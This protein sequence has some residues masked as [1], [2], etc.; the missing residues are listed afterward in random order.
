M[1]RRF[2]VTGAAGLIGRE[3]VRKLLLRGDEVVAILRPGGATGVAPGATVVEIDLSKPSAA[4]FSELGRYDVVIHLAQAAGWHDFPRNAGSIATVSLAATACLAEAAVAAGASTF[5]LASSGGIYGS[6]SAPIPEDAPIK[7]AAELGFYLA[8]KAC[9]EQLMSYFTGQMT[10]HKL[11]PFFVYGRGQG[12]AFLIPRLIRSV[13][14]GRSIKL[15][16]GSG[17][18]LNPI[19]VEDAA[20]AFLAT[21]ELRDPLVANIAGPDV[22]TVSEI[23][24]FIAARLHVDPVYEIVDRKPGDFVADTTRMRAKLGPAVTSMR[25]GLDR[26]ID[27]PLSRTEPN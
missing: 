22:V 27:T 7:P 13:K 3:V 19:F 2:V 6:S 9:A 23:V 14:E 8:T 5:V 17:P 20:D 10:V 11:R 21:A 15:D 12:E 25:N 24:K 4:T 18:R 1:A 16:G 26:Y